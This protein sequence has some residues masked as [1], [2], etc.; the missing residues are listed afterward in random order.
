[1]LACCLPRVALG[2]QGDGTSDDP[3]DES[4]ERTYSFSESLF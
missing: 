3:G 4:A 1:M 2:E